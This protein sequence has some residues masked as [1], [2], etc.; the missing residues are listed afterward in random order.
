MKLSRQT[1]CSAL[2][3]ATFPPPYWEHPDRPTHHR[4]FR[5]KKSPRCLDNNA[6]QASSNEVR[7]ILYRFKSA[8][9]AERMLKQANM[10]D[11]HS[12][13]TYLSLPVHPWILQQ[14]PW[15]VSCDDLPDGVSNLHLSSSFGAERGSTGRR[16]PILLSRP[17]S[18]LCCTAERNL[19]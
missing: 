12:T 17:P 6:L 8:N 2:H 11:G 10:W 16:T 4:I 19:K 9:M 1:S 13:G 14:F 5:Y 18:V 15:Q 7:C 3:G